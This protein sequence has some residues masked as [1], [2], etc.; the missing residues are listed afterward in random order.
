[1]QNDIKAEQLEMYEKMKKRLDTG[2]IK[3]VF[4]KVDQ[5]FSA[6]DFRENKVTVDYF[7]KQ[8]ENT[9]QKLKCGKENIYYVCLDPDPEEEKFPKL[10]EVGILGFEELF[11]ELRISVQ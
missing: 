9:D 8:R 6:R 2:H 10:K 1:M 11:D 5:K 3:V 4:N 7:N